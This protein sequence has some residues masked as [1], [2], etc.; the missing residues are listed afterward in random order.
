MHPYGESL[1]MLLTQSLCT[2]SLKKGSLCSRGQL[3]LGVMTSQHLQ[4]E[5]LNLSAHRHSWLRMLA[6]ALLDRLL[7]QQLPCTVLGL[8]HC[9]CL[10]CILLKR[11][12]ET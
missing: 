2:N 3:Q 1:Q 6:Q 8:L 7:S 4:C 9:C 11:S 12:Q 10:L 5:P